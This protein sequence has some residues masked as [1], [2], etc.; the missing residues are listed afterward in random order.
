MAEKKRLIPQYIAKLLLLGFSFLSPSIQL[1]SGAVFA[2]EGDEP[3]MT[4]W[5]FQS[6][7]QPSE[8]VQRELRRPQAVDIDEKGS[9]Y[10]ADTG[11]SRIIK[12]NHRMEIAAMTSGW[13]S[14]RD[15]MDRPV[16]ITS[17]MGLNVYVADYQNGR[18]VRFDQDLNFLWDQQLG[19][20]NETWEFPLALALSD[21]GELFILEETSGRIIRLEPSG[22]TA[23]TFG[24]YRPAEGSLFGAER[25]TISDDG[26]LF[27]SL[28]GEKAIIAYD[29][30]GNFLYKLSI[31]VKAAGI[32]CEGRYVWL[33]GDEGLACLVG[34]DTVRIEFIGDGNLPPSEIVDLA[35]AAGRLVIL[36]ESEP[37]L[38]VY[39]LSKSPSGIEW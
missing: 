36:S 2:G 29:R 12:F 21:W 1:I 28:P 4:V 17:D 20:F 11:N 7:L 24:G 14:Q 8:E 19:F 23:E 15:L 31:P 32:D 33:G 16:D 3:P 9:I 18:I 5:L 22:S 27:I 10:L 30:Y 25:L 37:F 34:R 38:S 6:S 39:L 13:G 26:T 35:A